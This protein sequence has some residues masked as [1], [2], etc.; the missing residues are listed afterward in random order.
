MH[1]LV[2]LTV[3]HFSRK[4]CS[5]FFILFS[6]CPSNCIFSIKLSTSFLI[7]SSASSNLLVC[8]T[9]G[10][11]NF[12]SCTFQLQN[13]HLDLFYVYL[14]IDIIYLM[15]CYHHT[16]LNPLCIVSF[17]SLSM[18]IMAAVKSLPAKSDILILSR[19]LYSLLFSL[20]IGH[21]YL[22]VS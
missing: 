15:R 21:T 10:F 17:D 9:S 6:L 12:S 1:M 13:F 7:L 20:C 4:L 8:P 14:F 19:Q 18:F 16:F 5:F 22:P 2:H 3:S 11:L